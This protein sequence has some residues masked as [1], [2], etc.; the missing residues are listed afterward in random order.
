MDSISAFFSS[1]GITFAT[2]ALILLVGCLVLALLGRFIFGKRSL[3]NYSVSSAIA[4]LF[5]YAF[6]IILKSTGIALQRFV[7]PLP[8]VAFIADDMYFFS[9]QGA[10]YAEICSELL[11]MIILTFFVNIVD[12]WFSKAKKFFTW[13]LLRILTVILAFF[14]HYVIVNLFH[15]FLP[16]GLITYAPTV[17]LGI[18]VLMLL[19]GLLKHVL[20]LILT[21]V[22]PIIGG[23]YTFFFSTLI[24][25]KLT[26]AMLT[27]AIL[28]GLVWLLQSAG[29]VSVAAAI[30]ALAAYIPFIVILVAIWYLVNR[31][32]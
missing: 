26:T 24:G 27:T 15:T 16:E 2:G 23:L 25:K 1:N 29:I 18:L 13:L 4:I 32:L 30:A 28:T 8:F 19:T 22:N 7:A 9:F 31:L 20:G 6:A 17:L 10:H 14:G 12:S 3:L 5:L 11:S 21:T